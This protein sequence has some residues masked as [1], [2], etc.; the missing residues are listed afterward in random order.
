MTFRKGQ[1]I[2]VRDYRGRSF[3]R[4]VWEDTGDSV[5]VTSNKV[6]IQ[7]ER[8][9]FS[10]IPIRFPKSSVSLARGR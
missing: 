2:S 6:L 10:L 9:D 4:V 8:G 3:Q 5:F 1:L 7:L